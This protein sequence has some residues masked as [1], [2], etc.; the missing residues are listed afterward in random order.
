MV[1]TGYPLIDKLAPC[2]HAVSSV[3]RL[4]QIFYG[5]RKSRGVDNNTVMAEF[6]VFL[7]FSLIIIALSDTAMN[8]TKEALILLVTPVLFLYLKLKRPTLKAFCL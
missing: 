5:I 2:G 7:C 4:D 8:R 3:S 1:S 6:H